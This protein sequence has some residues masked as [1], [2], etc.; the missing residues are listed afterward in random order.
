[1]PGVANAAIVVVAAATVH[2]PKTFCVAVAV[3][4]AADAVVLFIGGA[5]ADAVSI[6]SAA[7]SILLP[8]GF[9][10]NSSY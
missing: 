4:T 3:A 2:A 7:V 1:M 6:V 9:C 10:C 8:P 5:V